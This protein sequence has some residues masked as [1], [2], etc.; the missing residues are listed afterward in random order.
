MAR[1]VIKKED[2]VEKPQ[3]TAKKAKNLRLNQAEV[4]RDSLAGNSFSTLTDKEKGDLLKALALT[5]GFIDPDD[6][7][8]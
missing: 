6:P 4:I 8:K 2:L 7:V 5:L 1:E 3:V